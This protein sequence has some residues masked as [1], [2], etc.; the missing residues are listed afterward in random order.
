[1]SYFGPSGFPFVKSCLYFSSC[2]TLDPCEDCVTQDLASS[3]VT[4]CSAP[5]EGTLG[6]NLISVIGD[7][8]DET[9]CKQRCLEEGPCSV[10]TYHRANSTSS[11]ETCFLLTA[12]GS[13]VKEC[14]DSTC[15]TGLPD[16]QVSSPIC[17]YLDDD[18]VIMEGGVK[19]TGGGEK[20]ITLLRLGECPAPVALAIG[21]GGDGEYSAGGGGSGYVAHS[22][23]LLPAAAY[24]RMIAFAGAQSEDSYVKDVASDSIIVLG[25]KGMDSPYSSGN[26]ADGGAGYSG[27]GGQVYDPPTT[28]SGNGGYDGSDGEGCS[29]TRAGGEGSNLDISTIPLRNFKLSPG[30]GGEGGGSGNSGGGGGGVLLDNTGPSRE[31]VFRG[32]GY[33]GGGHASDYGLPGVVLLDFVPEE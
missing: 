14:G 3:C 23:D 6:A 28:C 8:S 32:E 27:G 10:Y 16:C 15:V 1:M 30:Q 21:T 26:N 4:Y 2:D 29:S 20:N 25:E 22:V 9:T 13:P 31:D 24:V 33:G 12:V 19:V 11:P 5:I 17:S 7:V 18:G